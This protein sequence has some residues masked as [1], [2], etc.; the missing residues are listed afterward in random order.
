MALDK[1]VYM[2]KFDAHYLIPD[3]HRENDNKTNILYGRAAHVIHVRYPLVFSDCISSR[4]YRD[5]RMQQ[6]YQMAHMHMS[7][8]MMSAVV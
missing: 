5:L 8:P 1:G 7:S 2:R 3:Y 6:N 4:Y